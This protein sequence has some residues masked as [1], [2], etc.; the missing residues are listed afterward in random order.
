[1]DPKRNLNDQINQIFHLKRFESRHSL[2]VNRLKFNTFMD[3]TYGLYRVSFCSIISLSSKFFKKIQFHSTHIKVFLNTFFW[4]LNK[5]V[6]EL[7][8]IS[9]FRFSDSLIRVANIDA[10]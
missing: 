6:H 10:R 2:Y 8:G 3:P 7:A 5:L 1:M 9:N 4:F